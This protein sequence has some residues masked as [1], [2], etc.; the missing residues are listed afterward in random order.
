MFLRVTLSNGASV[1]VTTKMQLG[2][3]A[4][5]NKLLLGIPTGPGM[6]VSHTPSGLAI[7]HT[8]TFE[9]AEAIVRWLYAH[10]TIPDHLNTHHEVFRWWNGRSISFRTSIM[11]QLEA[12]A[13]R[14]T[15][16]GE[17]KT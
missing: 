10:V 17:P 14:Y 12:I 1:E 11:E 4:I 16:I 9:Q 13:P 2:A 15:Y 3:Y 7:W 6:T 8:E 5:H